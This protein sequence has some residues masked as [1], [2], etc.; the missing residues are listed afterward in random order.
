[1]MRLLDTSICIPLINGA[2]A[3]MAQRLLAHPPGSVVLCSVVRAELS[4]GAH[5]S[6]RAAENLQRVDTFCRAFKSLPF[7]DAAAE[8]YGVVRAQLR[9]EGRPIGANDLLIASIALSGGLTLVTRNRG[10][11]ARVPGLDVEVW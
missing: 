10:E 4:F 11:F 9:R 5:N 3:Q 6:V 1:M 2:D 8:R 7:D